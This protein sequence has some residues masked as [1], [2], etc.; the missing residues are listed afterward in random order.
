MGDKIQL[1]I[2]GIGMGVTLFV[3]HKF[4]Q[5]VLVPALVPTLIEQANS[6]AAQA[7][8]GVRP[9]LL[10]LATVLDMRFYIPAGL[11]GGITYFACRSGAFRRL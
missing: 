6:P 5:A 7:S 4:T 3:I 10:F 11:F 9:L 2:I 8:P 1:T